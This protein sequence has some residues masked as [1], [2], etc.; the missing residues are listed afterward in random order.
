[1]VNQIAVSVIVPI[2]NV[3]KYLAKCLDSLTNQTLKNIEIICIND[4][5][6]DRSAKIL[7][8]Y[9][10]K[11]SRII[12]INQKNLGL[13]IA[14][15][16][17]IDIAKGKYIGFVDSDDYIDLD[18]YE[19][20]YN[21]AT[22]NKCDIAACG[23]IRFNKI[24][25]KKYLKLKKE[26]ITKNFKEKCKIL[27]IPEKCY[28]WNK[29]YLRE[30]INKYNIRF[31]ENILYE[32]LYFTPEVL[33]KFETLITV[34]KTY[35]HYRKN[36]NSIVYTKCEKKEFFYKTG[37]KWAIDFLKQR[38]INIEEQVTKT[39]KY[40]ILGLTIFKKNTK[41]HKTT[42]S[43]LSVIKWSKTNT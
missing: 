40:K 2:Y 6:K 4:G 10:K 38:G 16:N 8:E 22:K 9:S 27:D 17:G 1:M 30:K 13:C 24:K 43:L 42:Y 3:E 25:G 18:F 41:A 15:N 34:P 23:I 19:K 36:P 11:D 37:K 26:I 12:T 35:Y 14:R 7:A 5:S 32:D 39:K 33:D 20:L 29:I 28:V 21:S 31:K